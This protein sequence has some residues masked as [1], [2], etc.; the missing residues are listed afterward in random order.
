MGTEDG[1]LLEAFDKRRI[2]G[3]PN[4]I[5]LSQTRNLLIATPAPFDWMIDNSCPNHVQIDV[6]DV[7]H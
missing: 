3:I 6:T 1:N 2:T 5:M 4:P 7:I